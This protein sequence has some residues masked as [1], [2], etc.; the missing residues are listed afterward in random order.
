[1]LARS[2]RQ[3]VRL[4]TPGGFTLVELLVVITIIGILAALLLG[5]AAVAAETGREA[6]TKQMITRLHTLLMEHYD[7]FQDRRVELNPNVVNY[8]SSAPGNARFKGEL[9]AEARL[10]GL[11]ELQLTEMPDKWSDILLKDLPISL[12]NFSPSVTDDDVNAPAYLRQRSSLGELFL[13]LFDRIAKGTNTITGAPNT[14]QEI[15]ANQSAECLYMVIIYATG[16][17]E[18]RGLFSE[19]DIADT[20]GDG[21]PEF[22]DAWGNPIELLRWAPDCDSPLQLNQLSLA[23][24]RE[25]AEDDDNEDEDGDQAVRRAISE[26]RT[27]FDPW[28]FYLLPTLVDSTGLVNHA[29]Y[30][31]IPY[32]YSRGWR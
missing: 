28:S 25:D 24:L 10:H 27:A 11:R 29:G 30:S 19:T 22:V 1:M 18:A 20:D 21:A 14:R 4:T 9:T 16:D 6:K 17:G 23:L 15:L 13:G 31:L 8:I 3:I 2:D 32:I 26:N 12:V 5:V 7:S